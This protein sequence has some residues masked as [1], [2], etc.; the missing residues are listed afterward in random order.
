MSKVK[1]GLY[2]CFSFDHLQLT[3]VLNH[4]VILYKGFTC[5]KLTLQEYYMNETGEVFI[6]DVGSKLI[7]AM[8][9]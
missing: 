2:V 1:P 7:R 8:Y 6:N 5:D 9:I 3:Y 4:K